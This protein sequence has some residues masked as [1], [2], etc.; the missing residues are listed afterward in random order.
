MSVS[1]FLQKLNVLASK[2][3]NNQKMS[4]HTKRRGKSLKVSHVIPNQIS[5]PPK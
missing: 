4:S 1:Y 3:K 2:S 5:E